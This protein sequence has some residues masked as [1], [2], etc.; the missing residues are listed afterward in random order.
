MTGG[1]ADRMNNRSGVEGV[2]ILIPV[3]GSEVAEQA[4]Q[5]A[6]TLNADRIVL[7]R[8]ETAEEPDPDDSPR[9]AYTRWYETHI[10]EVQEN[11]ADLQ[12]RYGS[13][14]RFVEID[15]RH[16]NPA[17]AIIVAAREFDLVV[18]STHGKGVVGRVV[19]GSTA[20]RVVRHGTTPVLL[21]RID[22]EG[23][24]HTAATRV[25][26]ALDGSDLAEHAL[27]VGARLAKRLAVPMHLVRVVGMDDVLAT[28]RNRRSTPADT[29]SEGAAEDPYED[30]RIETEAA[31]EYYL[32]TIR[33][34][35][36]QNGTDV[37][38]EVRGGTPVFE[39]LWMTTEE[40]V[41]VLTSRGMGGYQRWRL[42]ST[43]ERLVRESKATVLLVPLQ[44]PD[45]HEIGD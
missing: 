44:A 1:N 17:E 24:S 39:L 5:Y 20:D 7:M 26:V 35:M 10:Q 13:A 12:K 32:D 6:A 37:S 45:E 4:I 8:V 30:A 27:P 41:V 28:V 33:A 21:V 14:A 3:D 36:A 43:A 31:A 29:S 18:M 23:K 25:V 2:N 9:A 40:D 38:T 42:G 15:I 34:D 11:L 22:E 16:G 19:F